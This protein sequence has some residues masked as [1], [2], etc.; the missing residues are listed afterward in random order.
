MF[1]NKLARSST[2]L[3]PIAATLLILAACVSETRGQRPAQ[4]ARDLVRAIERKEMDQLLLR[5]SLPA[6]SDEPARQ[7]ILK[8]IR[9]DFRDL[10]SLN[11][12]M[13]SDSWARK[14]MDY[15]L[16]SDMVSRIRGK[17][18][19]LK[20]NLNLPEPGDLKSERRTDP[21][22]DQDFRAS[23]MILDQTIMRFVSNPLFQNPNT[24]EVTQA[25]QA[26]QDLEAVIQLTADLKKVALRL[27]KAGNR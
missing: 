26:R 5:K 8:Q 18:N 16:V 25:S 13:M 17:A 21:V 7:V 15:D 22:T 9:D 2:K 20:L 24:V 10:Q 4:P 3:A 14:V 1:S 11:N 27:G 19:R 12:R 23:L 6:L